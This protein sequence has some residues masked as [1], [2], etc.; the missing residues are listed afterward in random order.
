MECCGNY[1]SDRVVTKIN[2]S[3]RFSASADETADIAGVEQ[4]SVYARY[5][6][7]TEH[8]IR[9]DFHGFPHPWLTGENIAGFI[10]DSVKNMGINLVYLRRQDYAGTRNM[11]GCFKGVQACISKQYTFALYVHCS[12]HSL[13]LIVSDACSEKLFQICALAQ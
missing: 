9:E 2:F 10:L 13:N 1:I 8:R 12:A 4:L 3:L 7:W 5:I 11:S 6:D